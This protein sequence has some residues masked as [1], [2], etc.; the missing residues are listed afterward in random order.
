MVQNTLL[1]EVMLKLNHN[2]EVSYTALCKNNCELYALSRPLFA[3]RFP[4]ELQK[5]FQDLVS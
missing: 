3:K 5:H 4:R 1:E 2:Y